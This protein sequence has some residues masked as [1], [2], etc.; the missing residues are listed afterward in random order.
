[1]PMYVV[2]SLRALAPAPAERYIIR[3]RRSEHQCSPC[4]LGVCVRVPLGCSPRIS[5]HICV[6]SSI[7]APDLR[8]VAVGASFIKRSVLVSSARAYT[9]GQ[10]TK[11]RM[12]MNHSGF[13]PCTMLTEVPIPHRPF[14]SVIE[15]LAKLLTDSFDPVL[16]MNATLLSIVRVYHHHH[17]LGRAID[18]DH[19]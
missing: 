7:P 1:M 5:W 19:A 12:R 8:R 17:G 14:N 13:L 11:Q 10:R 9:A 2:S 3:C 15:G 18:D 16:S 6:S 4:T